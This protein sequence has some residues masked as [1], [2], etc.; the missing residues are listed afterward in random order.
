MSKETW[1]GIL[2]GIGIGGLAFLLGYYE[3]PN[4]ANTLPKANSIFF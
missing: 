1:R 2:I 3:P 4:Y